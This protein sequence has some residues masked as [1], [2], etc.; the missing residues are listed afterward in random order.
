MKDSR[1]SCKRARSG[2]ALNSLA[3]LAILLAAPVYT[4]ASEQQSPPAHP[5]PVG[6][7]AK[8]L[9]AKQIQ[10]LIAGGVDSRRLALLVDSRGID[11]VPSSEFLNDL[12]SAGVNEVLIQALTNARP[13]EPGAP[14]SAPEKSAPPA[15]RPRA[16]SRQAAPMTAAR[17]SPSV[18]TAGGTSGP[19]PA[20]ERGLEQDM[21]RA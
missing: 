10:G 11:F 8:P 6:S 16:P 13:V 9:T 5:Q 21:A 2:F 20:L 18:P 15:A 12:K 19:S 17:S 4:A 1:L 14:K 7:A 3:A